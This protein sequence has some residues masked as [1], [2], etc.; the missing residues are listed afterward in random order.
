MSSSTTVSL[1][2]QEHAASLLPTLL[3]QEYDLQF[4]R[5]TPDDALQLG[6][7]LVR[8]AKTYHPG[9]GISILI[10]RNGQVLFQHAME[11]ATVD[12]ENWMRRKTNTVIRLQHSSYYVGRELL[13]KGYKTMEETYMVSMNDYACHGGG[14]PLLIKDVGCIGC[15]V[16]S[17]LKQ[18]EDHDLVVAG[19]KF[20]LEEQAK[21]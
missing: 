3:R 19:I 16:V 12:N 7:T 14:F 13:S 17:G 2:A 18:A 8:L 4:T 10:T 1:E 9:R 5:F 20:H 11:G 21:Q 6:T 15:I